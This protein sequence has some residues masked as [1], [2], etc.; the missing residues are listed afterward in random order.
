MDN[1]DVVPKGLPSTDAQMTRKFEVLMARPG[2][3]IF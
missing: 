1:G 3:T 2:P